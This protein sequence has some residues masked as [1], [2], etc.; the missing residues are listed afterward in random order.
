MVALTDG[1][2]TGNVRVEAVVKSRRG[3][4]VLKGFDWVK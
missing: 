2:R 4:L 3:L 1:S